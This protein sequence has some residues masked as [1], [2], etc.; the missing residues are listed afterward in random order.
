MQTAGA[1]H[2]GVQLV[3]DDEVQRSKDLYRIART[4]DEHGLD[5]LGGDQDCTAWVLPSAILS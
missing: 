2:E 5:G 3:D 1:F 4:P